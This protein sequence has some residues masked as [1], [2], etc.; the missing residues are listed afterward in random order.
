MWLVNQLCHTILVI[1]STS[2]HYH[3]I[4]FNLAQHHRRLTMRFWR[5]SCIGMEVANGGVPFLEGN[6]ELFLCCDFFQ[7]CCLEAWKVVGLWQNTLLEKSGDFELTPVPFQTA[8]KSWTYTSLEYS[9]M[10]G[11]LLARSGCAQVTPFFCPVCTS[12]CKFANEKREY[13]M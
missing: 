10:D 12:V 11:R 2:F 13:D 5:R 1:D 8:I 7:D 3:I 6:C 4:I 9:V